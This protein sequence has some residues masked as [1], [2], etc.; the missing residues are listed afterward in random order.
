MPRRLSLPDVFRLRCTNDDKRNFRR[1]GEALG[2]KDASEGVRRLSRLFLAAPAE[3]R[4]ALNASTCERLDEQLETHVEDPD[5]G[6][7]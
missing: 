7:G 5:H 4:E 3:V 1:V 2:A 6:R